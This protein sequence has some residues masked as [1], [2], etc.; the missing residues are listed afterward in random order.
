MKKTIFLA[1]VILA[2]G[3]LVNAQ[4][5]EIKPNAAQASTEKP[6]KQI[7]RPNKEQIVQVQKMLKD[8]G[9]YAGE[10]TGK[11]EDDFRESIN[12]RSFTS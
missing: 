9:L 1:F 5:P 11:M 8:K 6:K 2:F 7:F 10:A 4:K 3:I 12:A